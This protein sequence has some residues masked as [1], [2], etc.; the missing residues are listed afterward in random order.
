M[1]HTLMSAETNTKRKCLRLRCFQRRVM[2][3]KLLEGRVVITCLIVWEIKIN[4]IPGKLISDNQMQGTHMYLVWSK[5]HIYIYIYQWREQGFLNSK[6]SKYSEVRWSIP[7]LGD[8]SCIMLKLLIFQ[9][10]FEKMIMVYSVLYHQWSF[11]QG[12]WFN[13]WPKWKI[14]NKSLM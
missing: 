12:N 8:H 11:T 6:T 13:Y 4:N 2:V 5:V 3:L 7:Y 10:N 9:S 14:S 1:N